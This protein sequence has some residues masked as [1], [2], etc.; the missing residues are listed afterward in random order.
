MSVAASE[1]N[2]TRKGLTIWFLL[3]PVCPGTGNWSALPNGDQQESNA[4]AHVQCYHN[5]DAPLEVL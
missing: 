5:I 2:C 1:L 4:I 3:R